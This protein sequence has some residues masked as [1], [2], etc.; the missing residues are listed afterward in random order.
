MFISI[1][2]FLIGKKKSTV[3]NQTLIPWS[4]IETGTDKHLRSRKLNLIALQPSS[5][6]KLRLGLEIRE[7]NIKTYVYMLYV[8]AV[9]TK[10]T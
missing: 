4:D 10:K 3:K 2:G 5:L 6:G 1:Y 8:L 9:V 7:I